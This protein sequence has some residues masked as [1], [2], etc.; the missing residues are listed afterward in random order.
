MPI[1]ACNVTMTAVLR[2]VSLP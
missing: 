1:I 2:C